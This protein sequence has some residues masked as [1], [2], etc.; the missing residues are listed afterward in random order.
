MDWPYF[1]T[2][3]ARITNS[4]LDSIAG[5][6]SEVKYGQSMMDAINAGCYASGGPVGYRTTTA[7]P[8]GGAT[9]STFTVSSVP[10][11]VQLDG[12]EIAKSQ[13][14]VQRQSGGTITLG[15]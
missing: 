2:D 10:V 6:S 12:R 13:L 9:G 1:A 5:T 14:K 15:G 11:I 7:A 8:A 4:P 3:A